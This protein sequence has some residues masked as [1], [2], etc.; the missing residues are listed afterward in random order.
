MIMSTAPMIRLDGTSAG[1]SNGLVLAAGSDGSTIRGL[2][3]TNYDDAGEGN[4]IV[5]NSDF[6]HDCWQLHRCEF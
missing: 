3:I 4:A 5:I 1:A 6:Q 2:A